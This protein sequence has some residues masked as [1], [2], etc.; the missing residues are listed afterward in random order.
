MPPQ[1]LLITGRKI[2][3]CLTPLTFSLFMICSF[4]SSFITHF[5]L[6][7]Q[8]PLR[9]CSHKESAP[10]ASP[11]TPSLQGL[12][13]HRT[14]PFL[15]ATPPFNVFF[16][17]FSSFPPLFFCLSRVAKVLLD[18]L[19]ELEPPDGLLMG[20]YALQLISIVKSDY[21]TALPIHKSKKEKKK[22]LAPPL[23]ITNR[24]CKVHLSL[25]LSETW[26]GSMDTCDG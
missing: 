26:L 6:H 13:S 14:A 2:E 7:L 5:L 23:L 1:Y 25:Y 16:C 10:L 19:D 15:S 20:S 21:L 24:K 17:S 3:V 8:A 4:L 18:L 9:L 22:V 11:A 12:M